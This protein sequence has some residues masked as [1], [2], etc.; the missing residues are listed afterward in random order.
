M[1]SDIF[2]HIL[3]L[4]IASIAVI[5]AA[6]FVSHAINLVIYLYNFFAHTLG[7]IFSGGYVGHIIRQVSSLTLTAI[8]IAMIPGGLY[9]LF[10]RSTMPYLVVI[11]WAIWLILITALNL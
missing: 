1:K 7:T 5:L 8:V 2:K 4:I 6:Q 3:Y 9:W 11:M 10:K